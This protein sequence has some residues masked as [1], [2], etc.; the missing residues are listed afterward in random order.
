[1]K[2]QK[3]GFLWIYVN[4]LWELFTKNKILNRNFM[5][6]KIFNTEVFKIDGTDAF[7]SIHHHNNKFFVLI[8]VDNFVS[9]AQVGQDATL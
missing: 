9:M 2:K 5:Y 8:H 7:Y 3:K 4:Q 6:I 1:M